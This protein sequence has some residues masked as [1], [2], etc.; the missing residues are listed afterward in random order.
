MK[1]YSFFYILLIILIFILLFI[2]IKKHIDINKKESFSNNDK[3]NKYCCI[4]AYY[5]KDDLYKSNFQYFLENGILDNVDYYIV[6][7]GNYTINISKRNNFTI[8]TRENKGYDFGAYS[9][10]I[11]RIKQN[12]DYYIFLNATVKG[13]YLDNKNSWLEIFLSLFNTNVKLVGSSICYT[14]TNINNKLK[15]IIVG[16]DNI[17]FV[18]TPFFIIKNDF[19]MYLNNNDFFNED[20]LNNVTDLEYVIFNKEIK[21]SYLCYKFGGNINCY[22]EKYRN[23]DYTKLNY[24]INNSSLNGDPYFVNTY[25][26]NTIQPND[27][28]FYKNKRFLYDTVLLK[29]E[30]EKHRIDVIDKVCV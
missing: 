12:Y 11:K 10:V 19:L 5:E 4:Y 24:D 30:I 23:L 13:P 15:D 9:Y 29:D 18:Q 16:R 17:Y 25:F 28:I 26:C 7:N 3:K 20:E 1:N 8:L 27:V 22:L 2:I 14:T 6:I 21:L